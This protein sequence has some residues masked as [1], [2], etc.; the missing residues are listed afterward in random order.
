MHAYFTGM[1]ER[2]YYDN[3]GSIYSLIGENNRYFVSPKTAQWS[4]W[5]GS[6][7]RGIS[8]GKS[9]F[10]D[11][12]KFNNGDL[13]V[14]CG[15]HIGDLKLYFDNVG[16]EVQYVGFEPSLFEFK[17]LE[18]NV[19]PSKVYNIG[20]W[21]ENGYLDFYTSSFKSDSSFI[22]PKT[23]TEISK[24][25]VVSLSKIESRHIKLL[26]LEAEG[27]EP[28]VL[29]GCKEIFQNID[30]IAADLGFERGKSEENTFPDCINMLLDNGFKI[31]KTIAPSGRHT[32]LFKNSKIKNC[33]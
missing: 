33:A 14:D 11:E 7:A 4:Y 21:N 12:I 16:V 25:R 18:R 27:G 10:L 1:S 28:E 3:I 2:L 24:I 22:Q 19:Y 17:C 29:M 8:L 13:V 6:K 15:A 31:L 9:Y 30:Y 23:Y 26:K 32:V 20:L 5:N